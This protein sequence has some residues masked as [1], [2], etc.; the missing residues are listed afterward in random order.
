MMIIIILSLLLWFF[1]T[2]GSSSQR[3]NKTSSLWYVF[4]AKNHSDKF[5]N[6]NLISTVNNMI[7]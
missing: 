4:L 7:A 2:G 1:V 5:I 3:W 6:Q